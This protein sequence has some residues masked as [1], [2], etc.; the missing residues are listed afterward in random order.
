MSENKY[1]F[2]LDIEELNDSHMGL[3]KKIQPKER[4]L[5]LGCSNGKLTQY[6]KQ[7][8]D[9]DV[10]GV[11][12]D[13]Q[14]GKEASPYCSQLIIADLDNREW[15]HELTQQQFDVILCADVLEHLKAPVRVLADLK[16][17]LKSEGRLL[18]SIPNVAHA[19]IRLELLQGQFDYEKIGLLDET[20]LHFYSRKSLIGML[21]QAG[22]LCCDIEYSVQDLA[23]EAIED[24]LN[25]AG[26]APTELA[27]KHL[28][29]PDAVA[30][31][32]MVEALPAK[33]E[34]LEHKP[35]ILEPK[36]LSSSGVYY[37]EKQEKIVQLE[38]RLDQAE[39]IIDL[40]KE[41]NE[42]HRKHIHQLEYHI[43]SLVAQHDERILHLQTQ[44]NTLK[45]HNSQISSELQKRHDQAVEK[46]QEKLQFIENQH[47]Q[48]QE[49]NQNHLIHIGNLKQKIELQESQLEA[50]KEANLNHQKE[51]QAWQKTTGV[52]D[53]SL[54]DFYDQLQTEQ[55]IN[56]Q[57]KHQ[58]AEMQGKINHLQQDNQR[59]EAVLD[60]VHQK[61][62]YKLVRGSK[63]LMSQVKTSNPA[64]EQ[65]SVTG[66]EQ[67][68]P[69]HLH[70]P[71]WYEQ[72]GKASDEMLAKAKAEIGKW[73]QSPKIAIL[74]P[75]YNPS[76]SCLV[77]AIE[78]VLNQIYPN[79]ELC[80]ADDCSTENYVSEVLNYFAEKDDRIKLCFR[81]NNGHI[82]AA[83]NSAL[84]L[85]TADY[86]ALMD[87][88]DL[89]TVD[90]LYWLAKVI[91]QCPEVEL[92]YT[93][94]DKMDI[95]GNQYAPY[96]KPDWNPELLLSHNFICHLAL[97]KTAKVKALGGFKSEFDGAQDYDL[98]LR[99]VADLEED[100]I[101]HVPRILYH[102]RAVEGSTANGVDA[103]PY[104][105][106][107]IVNVVRQAL[108]QKQRPALV[109]SHDKLPGSLR[110]KYHLIEPKPRVSIIIPTRN[111][112]TLLKRCVESILDKTDYDNYEMIIVDNGSDDLISQRYL[113]QLQQNEQ[114]TVIRD[115]SPFN[116]AAIN[117]RAVKQAKGDVIAL[118]NNDLEILN[119]DW[120]D[121]ML[122]HVQHKEVGAVGAKLYYPDDKIQHAGVIV[123][124]GGVAGHSHKHY[125]REH[126]GYCG[127]LLL[128]QNLSA[129]T[130]ACMLLR[131]EVFDQVAGFDEHNLSV[132]FNDVDLCLRIREQG[133]QIVW[134]PY[135]EMYH[136]E[137]ASRGYEDTPEKKARFSQEV[138][139]MKTRWGL[140]LLKDP[141]YNPNL[142][143]DREDFTFACP[144]Q[145]WSIR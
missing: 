45:E 37:S 112:Y 137:S 105:E 41:H 97:Y 102:W 49:H 120:L 9:C 15:I 140:S 95:Q 127:R 27:M 25:K 136:Y 117:N 16:P 82:S 72:Y 55:Q 85:V 20:H 33:K 21:M 66:T 39:S 64:V 139:Y 78:S 36:P 104:S 99:Y 108:E 106:A 23:D 71:R 128:S 65:N 143:L 43:K 86:V 76:K 126:P 61:I 113:Y 80:I 8:L 13:V 111:G 114:I 93:D 144:P 19:S 3:A 73:Q 141:A 57:L 84:D 22:Y 10:V 134:T 100:K 83:S 60:R 1:N 122:S 87:H 125:P 118:L 130:A 109:Y 68:L 70:Y 138:Q 7:S 107:Q 89:L 34:L 4:V 52:L 47:K 32:F 74:M 119:S 67:Q 101:F 24:H 75:V 132:A 12:I 56:N 123:G 29:E 142:T 46:L 28:H 30:Y 63:N 98:V 133:Y 5:E 26:L 48:Q 62:S 11:E 96:F 124:L 40:E 14:A 79:F 145:E 44:Q 31:Q 42:N 81:D 91:K 77:N 50:E 88:D 17:Y 53:Q 54:F 38:K 129:V 121:E 131:R 6:L 2:D 59:L 51:I 35:P 116:Y 58:Q 115:D 18:A 103:K 92:I 110:V 94:E 69:L 135:A 90:A